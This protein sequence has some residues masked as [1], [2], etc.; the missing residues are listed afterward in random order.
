[1]NTIRQ[2]GVIECGN[3]AKLFQLSQISQLQGYTVSKI[4]YK[5]GVPEHL[6][7]KNHPGATVVDHH[8]AIIDDS[9]IEMV[10]VSSPSADEMNIVG[11]MLKANKAT[12][13]V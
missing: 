13:V 3:P 7:S 1:M 6:I 10:I 12:R 9:Q 5:N 8:Q 11:E 4:Y 2:I